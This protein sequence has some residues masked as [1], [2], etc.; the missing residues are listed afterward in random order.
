LGRRS[1]APGPH[2]YDHVESSADEA[3]D[4]IFVWEDADDIGTAHDLAVE[5]F[6]RIDGMDFRSMVL[7]EAHEGEHVGF[8]FIHEGGELGHLGM[9]L[10]GDGT[11]FL[12][13]GLGIVLNEG[14]ADERGNDAPALAP[15]MWRQRCQVACKTLATAALMPSWASVAVDS[16][17]NNQATETMRPLSLTFT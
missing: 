4:C 8:R 14:G 11:P 1:A 9:Q 7:G 17:R 5:P 6:E 3:G 2:R 16:D 13:G 12:A 10:I 15:G